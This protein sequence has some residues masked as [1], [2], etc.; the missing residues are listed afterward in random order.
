MSFSGDLGFYLG[1]INFG[2]SPKFL[3]AYAVAN[4]RI[5]MELSGLDCWMGV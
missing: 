5:L 1:G 3:D 4:W 2:T